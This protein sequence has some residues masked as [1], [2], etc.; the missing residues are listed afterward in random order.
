M[1]WYERLFEIL[2][3]KVNSTSPG[4]LSVTAIIS[5]FAVSEFAGVVV[6][7]SESRSEQIAK[8][9]RRVRIAL[10]HSPRIRDI[11]L[12][13]ETKESALDGIYRFWK[14]KIANKR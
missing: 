5:K 14:H 10:A 2:E 12:I 6:V 7:K 4:L 11:Y 13:R 1:I 8:K 9:V 3:I